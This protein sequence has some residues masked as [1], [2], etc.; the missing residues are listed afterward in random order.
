MAA[1]IDKSPETSAE[2]ARALAGP[3]G[4][5]SLKYGD[6]SRNRT[7]SVKFDLAHAVSLDGDTAP[8]L[9]YARVRALS[10]AAAASGLPSSTRAT[11]EL[12]PYERKLALSI[13]KL[14]DGACDA[15]AL[16]EPHRLCLAMQEA[17]S[18]FS[19]FYINCH[20]VDKFGASDRLRVELMSNFAHAIGEGLESLGIDMVDSMPKPAPRAPKA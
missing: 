11:Q 6:L 20:C 4:I 13:A 9:I 2:S 19:G 5:G 12:D 3:L 15:L 1:T 14:R 10:A 18:A 7:S 8:Y 16:L 17:A